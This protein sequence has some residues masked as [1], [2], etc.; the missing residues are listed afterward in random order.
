MAGK[1]EKGLG[2]MTVYGSFAWRGFW[3]CV[4]AVLIF[5]VI[6]AVVLLAQYFLNPV[7]FEHRPTRL[8]ESGD[9]GRDAIYQ[10][11]Q[12]RKYDKTY[13]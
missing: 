4:C 13:P 6:L 5:C 10:L 2:A 3:R 7:Y 8:D 1:R 11:E 12:E 9:M